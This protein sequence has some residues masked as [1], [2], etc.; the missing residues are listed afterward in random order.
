MSAVGGISKSPTG[1]EGFDEL[2]LGGLP[3]GRPTL[4]CGSAGCGKT[5]FAS[6]FLI[7]GARE[8]DEPGVFVTF[9]ER[10]SDIVSNVASLGFEMDELIQQG[11]LHIE[12]IQLDPAELA[13]VGDY[14]LEGLF[15]RLELA[16]MQTGAKRVVLDT[17]ESLFSAFSNPA[18]L[19]AEI[20][21]LFDWLKDRGLTTVITAERGDG[22][23]T[24]QGLEEY[25]S[26]CVILLDHRV[27]NQISTRRLRIVKYRGTAHGT[28]EYPFLIDRDGFS[29]LPVSA[30]GLHH[31]VFEERVQ[32]GIPDLDAMVKGGGFHRASSILI[33]GVAGS[34]K[35]S[36]AACFAGAACQRGEKALYFSFEE[37]AAQIKRNMRAIGLDLQGAMDKGLLSIVST[38]PTFYSLEMHLAVMLRAV[39][40]EKP[41]VVVLDPIS[42]FLDSG[43][44]GEVQSMLLR[45]VDYL[46][47]NGITAVFTHLSHEQGE[48]RTDAGLSSLMDAWILLLNREV[49]G[50]FNRELYLLK[51]RGLSH[52][53]Q[54][55]EFL[56]ADSGI[57]LIPPFL[58]EEG[59]LTGTARRV[60]EARKRRE[61]HERLQAVA[62]AQDQIEVRRRRAQAQIEALQ[63]ELR[64]DDIELARLLGEEEQRLRQLAQDRDVIAESRRA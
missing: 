61:E 16:V 48:A 42:A 47:T 39:A 35:S 55:R 59:A 5:L 33:S 57:S 28:N 12:H 52:S 27:Q 20:R 14:D 64:A 4:V 41:S 45:M 46:K 3:T 19:R 9:E 36:M 23:L 30:L 29:V 58:G 53:N 50:E 22:T 43:E 21:R 49:N 44:S 31:R 18:V 11:R 40:R 24:R 13:E 32:S 7:R 6:T 1:I 8:F 63:A 15:L 54:V 26:D 51:A 2:T 37:S 60:E 62:R 17:I 38:R 34:G 25:V 10:P 56:I